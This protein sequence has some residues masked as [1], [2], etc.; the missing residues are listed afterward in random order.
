[1]WIKKKI[2]N[3]KLISRGLLLIVVIYS[4]IF[5]SLVFSLSVSVYKTI[6]NMEI[7]DSLMISLVPEDPL[8]QASYKIPNKGFSDISNLVIDFK[9]DL[10]YS[11]KVT[12][13]ERREKLFFKSETVTKINPWQNYEAN[14][15]GGSEYFNVA[16][17]ELFWDSANF[18][19]PVFY[20]LDINITGRFLFGMIPFKIIIVDLNPDCTC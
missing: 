18:S 16:A 15:E 7:P 19:K 14:L 20:L 3:F 5:A 17:I 1:M 13:N 10:F 12:N 2:R 4:V 11:E 6:E 9:V 8:L